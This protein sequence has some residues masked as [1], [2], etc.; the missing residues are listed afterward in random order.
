VLNQLFESSEGP[1]GC[2]EVAPGLHGSDFVVLDVV[3]LVFGVVADGQGESARTVFTLG[4]LQD[5][6]NDDCIVTK[7]TSKPP[8]HCT[9]YTLNIGIN[10]LTSLSTDHVVA[11]LKRL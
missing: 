5:Q 11:T 9:V 4:G 6:V 10:F 3:P 8:P 1:S 7:I 2:D